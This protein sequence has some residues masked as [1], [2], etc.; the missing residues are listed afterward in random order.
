MSSLA[1]LFEQDDA[2][3]AQMLKELKAVLKK[4]GATIQCGYND[5]HIQRGQIV[6]VENSL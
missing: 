1:E 5:L 2:T 4:Y 6:R 3:Y